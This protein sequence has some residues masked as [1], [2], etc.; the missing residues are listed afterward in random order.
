[1]VSISL[2]EIDSLRWRPR[3]ICAA[4]L[5]VLLRDAYVV[6][7]MGRTV[8]GSSLSIV[9]VRGQG[10]GSKGR[11]MRIPGVFCEHERST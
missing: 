3:S 4:T 7:R 9:R 6:W 10:K 5:T 2:S 1:V 11:K 8:V